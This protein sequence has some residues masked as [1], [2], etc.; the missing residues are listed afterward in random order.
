MCSKRY[1]EL[2]LEKEQI[3]PEQAI[4]LEDE[5]NPYKQVAVLRHYKQV[6]AKEAM[7]EQQGMAEIEA[8]KN[9][10]SSQA[11]AEAEIMK[12]GKLTQMKMELASHES[13]LRMQETQ[14]EFQKELILA[15]INNGHDLTESEQKIAGS[16]ME[17]RMKI[18][19]AEKIAK[20]SNT[21]QI[22]AAKETPKLTAGAKK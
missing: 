13:G 1:I 6:K 12:G 20:W 15:K 5:K 16:I 10:Q 7:A 11:A 8:E 21:A 3:T 19:S 9:A 18:D 4:M 14:G 22:T 2:A 17:T